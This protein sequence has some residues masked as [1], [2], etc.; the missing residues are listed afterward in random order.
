MTTFYKFLSAL[1]ALFLISSTLGIAADNGDS[2]ARK[3]DA[4]L[5]DPSKGST[6]DQT[7]C[8]TAAQAAYDKRMNLAYTTLLKDLPTDAAQNLKLAQRAWISFRDTEKRARASLFE[9]RQGSMYAPME[10]DAEMAVT[11]DRALLLE[12]YVSVLK[13]D[14][15]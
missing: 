5:Q 7:D 11:R 15:P 14:G 12:S 8:E 3:L 2:T 4:C 1:F 10:A 6:G 13:I 9:T